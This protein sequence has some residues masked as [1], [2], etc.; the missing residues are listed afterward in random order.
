MV[1]YSKNVTSFYKGEH[2]VENPAATSNVQLYVKWSLLW[3]L[4]HRNLL[5]RDTLHMQIHL[6]PLAQ[7]LQQIIFQGH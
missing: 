2:L 1:S 5:I 3:N 7:F 4:L 6:R